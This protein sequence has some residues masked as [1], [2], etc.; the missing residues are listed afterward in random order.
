MKVIVFIVSAFWIAMPLWAHEGVSRS[1][2]HKKRSVHCPRF[3][4]LIA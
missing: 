1:E 2:P 4:G 3:P